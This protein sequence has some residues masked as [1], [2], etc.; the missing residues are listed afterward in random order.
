MICPDLSGGPFGAGV[1]R[2]DATSQPRTDFIT[3]GLQP[4]VNSLAKVYSTAHE[5][6]PSRSR[7]LIDFIPPAGRNS[8]R[9]PSASPLKTVYTSL[10]INSKSGRKEPVFFVFKN[11]NGAVHK[12]QSVGVGARNNLRSRGWAWRQSSPFAASSAGH[13]AIE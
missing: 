5:L 4:V 11:G 12:P 3:S 9:F 13:T 7:S 6:Q 10:K 2:T 1:V 8:V